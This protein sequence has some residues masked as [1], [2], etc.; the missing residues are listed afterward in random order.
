MIPSALY[1]PL[2]AMWEAFETSES[3]LK[4]A[5]KTIR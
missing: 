1:N 3:A 4:V 5:R 2:P